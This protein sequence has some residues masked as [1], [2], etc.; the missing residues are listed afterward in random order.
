MT[1]GTV[2]ASQEVREVVANT[3]GRPQSPRRM[4]AIYGARR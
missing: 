4:A 2:L 1:G 3:A